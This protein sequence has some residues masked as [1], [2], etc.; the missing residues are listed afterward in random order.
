MPA[1]MKISKLCPKTSTIYYTI[2]CSKCR[3]FSFSL[4]FS[5]VR[6]FIRF[7]NKYWVWAIQSSLPCPW[8]ICSSTCKLYLHLNSYAL[9]RNSYIETIDI[10]S[11]TINSPFKKGYLTFGN[12]HSLTFH[13]GNSDMHLSHAYDS[14]LLK[15]LKNKAYHVS[16]I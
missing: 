14:L 3:C 10:K 8:Y 2:F 7:G 11:S 12:K 6:H 5:L 4:L 1:A 9:Y 15:L 16:Q 13:N